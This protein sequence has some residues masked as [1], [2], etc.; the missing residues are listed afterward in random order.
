M[1]LLLLLPACGEESSQSKADRMAL[2]L[3]SE[4][5]A[6]TA[7]AGRADLTVDYGQRV[8]DFTVDFSHDAQAGTELV[9]AAPENIAGVRVRIAA[10]ETFLEYD[11]L[12]LE[13]GILSDDGLSPVSAL[14]FLFRELTEGYIAEC[15]FEPLGETE[16][17]RLI[18]RDPEGQPGS[19]TETSLWFD[20][21]TH[22]PLQA[23]IAVD[24]FTVIRCVLS[25]FSC[26]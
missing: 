22:L 10:G 12:S 9:L 7:C 13:T 3:R 1:I 17:L 4:Y 14:P 6:M 21:E 25:D 15:A 23:E 20:A 26:S 16:T 8:Y 18:C 11:D 19:G 2:E 5:L 24:G